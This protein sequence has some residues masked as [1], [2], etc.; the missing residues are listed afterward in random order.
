MKRSNL[1]I[2]AAILLASVSVY[3]IPAWSRPRQKPAITLIDP[4]SDAP[5]EI[6]VK[7][8][9]IITNQ[10]QEQ[11]QHLQASNDKLWTEVSRL[12]TG[13]QNTPGRIQ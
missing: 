9:I 7:V 3:V 11:V 12:N 6:K 8:L 13:K 10:L 5:L 4:N 1:I 2:I